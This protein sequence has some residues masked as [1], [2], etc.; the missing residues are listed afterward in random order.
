MISIAIVE[1]EEKY[2][3]LLQAYLNR[4]GEEN[5]LS[6]KIRR[7]S[8]AVSLLENYSADYDL[9]FMDI[10]MPYMN[11]MDAAH[12][13]REI[14]STVLLIFVTN[15]TQYAVNGYEVDALDY[16]VKPINYY[17]FALKLSRALG[18]IHTSDDTEIIL[19]QSSGGGGLIKIKASSIRYVETDGHRVVYHTGRGGD[20]TYSQSSSLKEAESKLSGCGFARCNSCYLVNLKY[21]KGVKGHTANVDGVE[22]Q[23]SQPRRKDFV[24]KLMDYAGGNSV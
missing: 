16:I 22:L 15:M 24:K 10:K 9:I 12:A 20:E 21:V 1:D 6:F 18:R 19:P 14:D 8:N 5:S 13:L 23:I 17:D 4:Y 3:E 7:F 2:A 11:G